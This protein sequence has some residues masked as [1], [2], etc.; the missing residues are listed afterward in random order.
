[1]GYATKFR[2]P[3]CLSVTEIIQQL[4]YDLDLFI[5]K[6]SVHYNKP[7]KFFKQWKCLM[8]NRLKLEL[9]NAFSFLV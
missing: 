3:S 6:I 9:K 5:Y 2:L 7:I 8:L 4:T 1:M